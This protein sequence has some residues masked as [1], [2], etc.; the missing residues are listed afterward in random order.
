MITSSLNMGSLVAVL[1]FS[2]HALCSIAISVAPSAAMVLTITLFWW[3]TTTA[4]NSS[5][6]DV[7]MSVVRVGYVMIIFA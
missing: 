2:M 5:C 1:I 4:Y 7:W 3:V 6:A